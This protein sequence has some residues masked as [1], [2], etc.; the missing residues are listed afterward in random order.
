MIAIFVYLSSSIVVNEPGYYEHEME[1][2]FALDF[3]FSN[4]EQYD[5]FFI[6]ENDKILK[7]DGQPMKQIIEAKGNHTISLIGYALLFR[8][9]VMQISKHCFTFDF[10]YKPDAGDKYI[11]EL[12]DL[13][14]NKSY[15]SIFYSNTNMSI[16]S[17]MTKEAN[18]D[19]RLNI[20]DGYSMKSFHQETL[21]SDT[22][23]SKN[24]YTPFLIVEY[25]TSTDPINPGSKA[26][27]T[28]LSPKS[29]TRLLFS[30]SNTCH[31][32]QSMVELDFGAGYEVVFYHGDRT[33]N[34]SHTL[35]VFPVIK[36]RY[37]IF[38]KF[39]EDVQATAVVGDTK[40]N[41]LGDTGIVGVS[42][43]G[44]G[45][46]T[47]MCTS[48]ASRLVYYTVFNNVSLPKCDTT[49]T[50]AGKQNY[51]T[52][53]RKGTNVCVYSAVGTTQMKN[54]P[55]KYESFLTSGKE[56]SPI[57]KDNIDSFP[58]PCQMSFYDSLN[59]INFRFLCCA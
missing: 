46:V 4:T 36:N 7:I 19:H 29:Y 33:L 52:K 22:V 39:T 34:V 31:Y 3:N 45:Y 26:G 25:I 44:T 21:T 59:D 11:Y 48:N 1:D 20:Y 23:L 5:Y 55:K 53:F 28:I 35:K 24:Y 54:P 16:V 14:K 58:D 49:L 12:P 42:F 9:S 6:P 47:I 13:E 15:C 57:S 38:Y 51:E 56:V 18:T 37:I 50:I 30:P 41:F 2:T 27:V 40:L 10:I 43:L 32:F 8:Y 17:N